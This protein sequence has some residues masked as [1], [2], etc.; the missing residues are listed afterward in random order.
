[1]TGLN[2][3]NASDTANSCVDVALDG[4]LVRVRDSKDPD[5]PT[6]AFTAAEWQ[7]DVLRHA[8]Q[9]GR[10]PIGARGSDGGVVWEQAGQRLVFTQ[11]EWMAFLGGVDRGIFDLDRLAEVRA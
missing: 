7:G 2:W 3:R 9:I 1:V 4:D 6:L 5:G 8:R 10:F 11:A